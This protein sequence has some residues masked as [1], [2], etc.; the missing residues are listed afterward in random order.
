MMWDE[1][2]ELGPFYALGG[3]DQETIRVIEDSL[4]GATPEQKSEIERWH[5]L[6]AFLPLALPSVRV[7]EYLREDLLNRVYRE[8]LSATAVIDEMY[9]RPEDGRA[10]IGVEQADHALMDATIPRPTT[11]SAAESIHPAEAHET[12]PQPEIDTSAEIL[13]LQG[14]ERRLSP[15]HR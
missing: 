5:E 6:V 1:L 7:P 14:T 10:I 2:E 8:S 3:L 12:F 4:Q 15:T 9:A 11:I 13:E